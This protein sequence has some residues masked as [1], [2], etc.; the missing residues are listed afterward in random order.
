MLPWIFRPITGLKVVQ[1]IQVI[2][3]CHHGKHFHKVNLVVIL[4]TF[5]QLVIVVKSSRRGLNMNLLP[6]YSLEIRGVCDARN[7]KGVPVNYTL[8]YLPG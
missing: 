3:E 8:P 1:L 4:V 6:S 2:H 5:R 7:D